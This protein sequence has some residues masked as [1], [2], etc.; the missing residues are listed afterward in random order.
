MVPGGGGESVRSNST[1]ARRRFI[2]GI[3]TLSVT[4]AG[5]LGTASVN[6]DPST[7]SGENATVTGRPGGPDRTPSSTETATGSTTTETSSATDPAGP[8]WWTP[9]G[10]V[11]DRFESFEED[12][13]VE[14]GTARL[15][16]DT[17]FTE[18]GAVRLRNDGDNRLRIVRRFETPRDFTGRDFSIAVYLIGSTKGLPQLN[19]TLVDA[20]GS[21][22]RLSGSIQQTAT[23]RWVRFDLGVREDAGADLG[24][25]E[26]VRIEHWTGEARTA[27]LVDEL[28]THAKPDVGQVMFT[29][30]D[31]G[32]SEYTVAYPVLRDHGYAGA[33]FP[34]IDR[35]TVDSTP[36]IGEYQEM[37][38]AGWDV[39]GHT[40]DHEDLTEHSGVEQR[41]IIEENYRKL[42][43]K[44]LAGEVNHFRTP[45]SNYD[46][47][48]LDLMTEQFDTA[49]IGAGSASG[50]NARISDHRTIGFRSGDDLE[51]AKADVDA[52]VEYRQFL[53]FTIHMANVD[54]AHLRSLVEYVSEYERNG[55][56]EV[57]TPTQLYRR[58][59]EP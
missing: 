31:K 3:G 15:V 6:N 19:L 12:W 44:G 32:P 50:T 28:R 16:D 57:L 40:L 17:T 43:E 22:R 7:S 9:D 34:P 27:F 54:E 20:A 48:S 10:R 36:S 24:A 38:D 13:T 52:A 33:S 59:V 25:I 58:F 56:L 18:G 55:D 46:S 53:G 8:S 4:I 21:Y 41:A 1:P 47:H 5:Y 30:D 11:L 51:A 39:G 42:Q 14:D 29:F 35:V 37:C 23:D 45:Y 2:A 49:I 26:A